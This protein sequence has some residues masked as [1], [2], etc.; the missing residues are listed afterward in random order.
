MACYCVEWDIKLYI[1]TLTVNSVIDVLLAKPSNASWLAYDG[2][3][4]PPPPLLTPSMSVER[5][6]A[7]ALGGGG[8]AGREGDAVDMSPRWSSCSK[9]L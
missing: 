1:F 5:R 7:A 4:P 6:R 8:R 3:T 9:L 2:M